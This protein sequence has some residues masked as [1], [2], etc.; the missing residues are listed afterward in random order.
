MANLYRTSEIKEIIDRMAREKAVAIV[1]DRLRIVTDDK[2]LFHVNNARRFMDFCS[3]LICELQR[4]DKEYDEEM[5]RWRAEKERREAGDQ[6]GE[7]GVAEEPA[8]GNDQ[9]ETAGDG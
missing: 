1:D 5:A 8:E 4:L 3:E 6:G 2:I 9:P 7:A